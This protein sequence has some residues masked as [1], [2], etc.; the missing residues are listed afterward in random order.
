MSDE[1]KRLAE[2]ADL[3]RQARE[4]VDRSASFRLRVLLDMLQLELAK[5]KPTPIRSDKP[6]E[7]S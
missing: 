7:P 3:C 4:S 5:E 6:D 1:Q 2:V